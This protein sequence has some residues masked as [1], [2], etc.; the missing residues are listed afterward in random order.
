MNYKGLEENILKGC[1][2]LTKKRGKELFNNKSIKTI[3]GKRVD[4]IYHIYGKVNHENKDFSTHI[5]YDLKK[6]KLYGFKCTCI[7]YKDYMEQ[8]YPYY[9]EHIAA[10]S[11]K[12]LNSLKSR[13]QDRKMEEKKEK[14]N[15]VKAILNIESKLYYQKVNGINQFFLE[16]KVGNKAKYPVNNIKTFLNGVF[17][18]RE[19]VITENFKYSPSINQ[20]DRVDLN[21]LRFIKDNIKIETIGNKLKI[22]QKQLQSLLEKVPR[23][24]IIFK[25]N[26][27]E[28]KTKINKGFLD[29]AFNL[30][31][32]KGQF[33]LWSE[34]NLPCPLDNE[35]RV[36]LF[37]REIYL[38]ERENS[39]K[40][41]PLYNELNKNNFKYFPGNNDSFIDIISTLSVI[42]R[43]VNVSEDL[44][45]YLRRYIKGKY[46]IYREK[47]NIFCDIKVIYGNKAINILKD[48]NLKLGWIR[49]LKYEE[50]LIMTF[51]RYGFIKS[52]GT[53]KFI[54]DD[55][56][57]Y[58]FLNSR[59]NELLDAGEIIIPKSLNEFGMYSSKDLYGT[60]YEEDWA[61]KLSYGIKGL[62]SNEFKEAYFAY[63]D[64]MRFYKTKNNSFIDLLDNKLRDL[65][66][67]INLL[68]LEKDLD[69]GIS[70]ISKSKSSLV[71]GIINR[72][73]LSFMYNN[74]SLRSV[75]EKLEELKDTEVD[76][77][78]ERLDIL[79]SYQY[80][81]VKW[82][83]NLYKL[84]FGG[85]LADEMG[86]GK[87]L[88][89]ISFL[90]SSKG[91]RF[92]I[93]VPT[94]LIFNW[95]DEFL[96]FAPELNLGIV[97]GDNREE[98][99]SDYKSYDGLITTY[100]VLKNYLDKF[101]DIEFDIC[102]IDEAQ[103]IKNYKS[104]NAQSVKNIKAKF[105][106]ALTGTPIE[107]NIK[108]LWSIFDFI[109][110]G[111]L[112]SMD[113]F[114]SKFNKDDE[115]SISLLK[116]LVNPFILRRT[117]LEVAKDLPD[118]NEVKLIVELEENQKF[119]YKNYVNNIKDQIRTDSTVQVLS[120]LTRLRQICLHPALVF[121]EYMG[122]SGK[123][124]AAHSIIKRA[125]KDNRKIL[126]FS[127]FTSVLDMFGEELEK[128]N[129]KFYKLSGE[130]SS[131]ERLNLVNSFN[132]GKMVN[133]FLISLKAGG[134]GLNLTSANLVI[135][136]DPWWNPA[137]E[138]QASDRA[139]RIGQK[140]DVEV[141][142]LIAKGTIEESIITLQE[143]KKELIEDILSGNNIKS[144]SINK[145]MIQEL[146]RS[147]LGN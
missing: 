48:N 81:G 121:P 68:N 30:R 23:E 140:N 110:P 1:A 26:Y 84:D 133:V 33:I 69:I 27:L 40:F 127:Q 130:T 72:C 86:L 137:V 114:N 85:I 25:D 132:E 120:Y 111:F 17:N 75:E 128:E 5:K 78:K 87:T 103:N 97:Y 32:E 124:K 95:R 34:K 67:M 96:K 105:K 108:E 13:I 3:Q 83:R 77:S 14:K 28:Y 107:N 61:I 117:K 63:K 79:R 50:R 12:F 99:I 92:F 125:I 41:T 52:N 53:M 38:L 45:N 42:T 54:G 18:N 43:K 116:S 106:L 135:H 16:F 74:E 60:V 37:N 4:D 70:Y 58:C 44:R 146:V 59:E 2:G 56:K 73:N 142:K 62:S 82:I 131:K 47:N 126:I 129:I 36:F 136:F 91:K 139:H 93:I 49:D 66:N 39:K 118:K 51:E 100:G 9:C 143:D 20:F 88:Q 46:F 15:E 115:K 8:G 90:A 29:L 31:E 98:I 109:M 21:Y 24:E 94:S 119:I 138:S 145:K 10:T 64:N 141:I 35:K 76:L 89:A 7:K 6:E 112:Y 123:F 11:F 19:V 147:Y 122:N 102:I 55:E 104:Q 71:Q 144:S 80:E 65:F 113:E 101:K 134:T 22:S 57:L